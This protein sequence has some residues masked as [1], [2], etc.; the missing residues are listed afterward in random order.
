MKNMEI[1]LK[2]SISAIPAKKLKNPRMGWQMIA[3]GEETPVGVT[4]PWVLAG[5]AV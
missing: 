4:L 5:I 1:A 3:Q 2:T